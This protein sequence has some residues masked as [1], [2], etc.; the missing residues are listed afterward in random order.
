M[1]KDDFRHNLTSLKSTKDNRKQKSKIEQG[2]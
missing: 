1:D 2:G